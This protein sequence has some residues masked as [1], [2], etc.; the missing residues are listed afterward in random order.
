[1]QEIGMCS[2]GR[3]RANQYPHVH[4]PLF[5]KIKT[6][7]PDV[8]RSLFQYTKLIQFEVNTEIRS[9]ID[10]NPFNQMCRPIQ[11]TCKSSII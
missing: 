7:T 11:V 3:T 8:S 6:N 9:A 4:L 1:M 5:V 10:V 2:S